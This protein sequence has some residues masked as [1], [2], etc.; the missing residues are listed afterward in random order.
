MY[1]PL[2]PL[3]LTPTPLTKT[4]RW[5]QLAKALK[6][7]PAAKERLKW[8]IWHET[9]ANH[10]VS[11]TCR[12]FG[13]ARKTW[14]KWQARFDPAN[15]LKL[16]DRPRRPKNV[17]Q[18]T[19]TH[20]QIYRVKTLRQAHL[21][22]GKEKLA[23]LY[24]EAYGETISSWKV[25]KIIQ[26]TNLYYHPRKNARIQAKRRK[27]QEKKRITE[28]KL[29]KRTG[30]LFR[31]DSIVRYWAGSKRYIIT[32][33]DSVSKLAFAHMYPSHSSQA[34][35]DFLRRLHYL[36]QGKLEYI[37]TD[38]GSE[39]HKD[40]EHTVKSLGLKHVW[41]RVKTP[42]DNAVCER[43]NRTL[44]EE[45]IQMGNATSDLQVFNRR[46]TDWLVEYNFRRPHQALGYMSP[47]NFIYKHERLLPM[48]PSSTRT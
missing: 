41:S 38:N 42:K 25:Q 15:L 40:F 2:R 47:I 39:F 16:E 36:T 11:L 34:A 5:Y 8:F 24:A 1:F 19:V 26:G 9:K 31:L 18:R 14:Y 10:D 46:L 45:F 27:A 12:H 22:Y 29:R 33:V 23:R 44:A 3:G 6:L 32:A 7:S 21:R 48:Y 17:R 35:S 30:F 4:K 28:L 13:I 43:F 20:L 37:Q